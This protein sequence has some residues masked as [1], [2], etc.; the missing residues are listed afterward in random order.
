MDIVAIVIL[1][2]ALIVFIGGIIVNRIMNKDD[3]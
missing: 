1:V 3:E 2:I